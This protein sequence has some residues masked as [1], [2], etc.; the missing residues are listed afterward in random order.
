MGATD[1][2]GTKTGV[3]ERM[4]EEAQ[5]LG[6]NVAE[7]AARATEAGKSKLSEQLDRQTS[8]AGAQARSFATALKRSSGQLAAE[9]GETQSTKLS[10]SVVERL[11]QAGAYLERTQGSQLLDDA[12]EFARRR[13]W[14][15]AGAAAFTGLMASRLLKASADQRYERSTLGRTRSDPGKTTRRVGTEGLRTSTE[16]DAAA[17]A[18]GV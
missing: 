8:Q 6:E 3:T 10:N 11:E 9:R 7:G 14:L 12:E 13:P 5:Q 2:G 18:S 4:Q 17:Y 16:R 15:V 1:A